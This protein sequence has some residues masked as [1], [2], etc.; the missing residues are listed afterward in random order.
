MA[1]VNTQFSIAVHVLA[2]LAHYGTTF[3]SEELAGSLNANP[4]F[5]KR[6]LVKL[7]K[8]GL[9]KTAVGKSGGYA[10]SGPPESISLRDIYS[11]VNSPSV[12][13]VHCYPSK[14]G[15]IVSSNVKEIMHE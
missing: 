1:S 7:S 4:V 11:A 6:V 15:C 10:L 12:F 2:A 3:T 9:V 8:A 13:A 14:K 5:V